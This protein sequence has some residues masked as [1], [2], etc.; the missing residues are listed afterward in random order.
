VSDR[1]ELLAAIK[2]KAVI[3][4]DFV[5]SSGQRAEWYVDLR[6]I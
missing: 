6:R 1:A 4:G 5:L 3:H 2:A